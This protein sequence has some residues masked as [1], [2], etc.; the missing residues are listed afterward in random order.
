M[1]FSGCAV[2]GALGETGI[3]NIKL[4][5]KLVSVFFYSRFNH[6]NIG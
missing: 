1:F 2:I 3:Q 6:L 4:G 5:K